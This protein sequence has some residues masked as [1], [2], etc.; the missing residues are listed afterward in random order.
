[1][2]PEPR[3]LALFDRS[4]TLRLVWTSGIVSVILIGGLTWYGVVFRPIPLFDAPEFLALKAE[5]KQNPTPENLIAAFRAEDQARRSGYFEAVHKLQTGGILLFLSLF[6]FVLALRR[7]AVLDEALPTPLPMPLPVKSSSKVRKAALADVLIPLPVACA[8]LISFVW[9]AQVDA[10]RNSLGGVGAEGLVEVET[11][12]ESQRWT[13]LRGNNGL[14]VAGEFDVPVAWN[15]ESGENIAWKTPIPLKGNSSPIIWGDRVFLT[16]ADVE[17]RVVFCFDL[18]TGALIWECAVRSP[19]VID[20]DMIRSEKM[21][22]TGFG[23]PTPVVNGREVIA[24][25]GTNEIAAVDFSGRQIWSKWLGKPN[26]MY[27]VATSL[28]L[29]EER[30]I[31]Q[32]DQGTEEEPES[33]L[34]AFHPADGRILWKADRE[35]PASWSTPIVVDAEGRNEIITVA[36]PWVISYDPSNGTEYWR[37]KVLKGDVAP[38]PVY[39]DG[40]VFT[41]V[42]YSQLAAVQAGGSGDV[43]ETH[44]RWTYD[45]ELPDIP[46]PLTDGKYLL[47]PTSYGYLLFFD[48]KTGENLW[49]EEIDAEFWSSPT[50]V[51]DKVYLTDTEGRTLIFQFSPTFE[52]IGEGTVGEKVVSSPAFV[53]SRILIRGEEHLFCIGSKEWPAD[54]KDPL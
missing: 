12:P 14:G 8:V 48:A 44:V 43:T 31:L 36:N 45:E 18:A 3:F 17:R 27:G 7:L 19:V 52:R 2:P 30:V 46:S 24:F 42:E 4:L 22:D 13:E 47:M 33:A 39:G 53:E 32:L 26:S 35:L 40:L 20:E 25:F 5:I 15:I 28:R 51:G 29:H 23:S 38:L 6:V 16:G 34:Y 21:G 1:M 41:A 50:L 11:L 9:Y 10:S 37:A 54:A 49:T